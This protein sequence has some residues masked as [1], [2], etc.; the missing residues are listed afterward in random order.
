MYWYQEDE[1]IIGFSDKTDGDLALYQLDDSAAIANWNSLELV[2]KFALERPFYAHQV[3]GC[4]VLAVNEIP[5]R[6]CVGRGDA[7]I[8]ALP[9]VPVGVFSADCLPLIFWNSKAVAAVHAGW[10]GSCKNI[11]AATLQALCRNYNLLPEQTK[12]AIGP[13][14]GPCCLEMGDEVFL[15]F[16]EENTDYQQFFRRKHKWQL[17]LVGLNRFQLLN[18]GIKAEHIFIHHQCTFCHEEKFF[19]FRRQKKRNGSMFSFAVRRSAN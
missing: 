19:S 6:L 10:R 1:I 11:A 14:I 16:V 5:T 17:D 18:A 2:K 13:C 8:T 12:V 7:L 9:N 4:E 15:Q 3:H